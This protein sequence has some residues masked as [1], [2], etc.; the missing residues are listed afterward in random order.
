M[1]VILKMPKRYFVSIKG[2]QIVVGFVVG[3]YRVSN[4]S[5]NKLCKVSSP[6]KKNEI[7]F[8]TI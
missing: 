4:T 2:R 6:S 8:Q 3:S 7:P 5:S 1:V